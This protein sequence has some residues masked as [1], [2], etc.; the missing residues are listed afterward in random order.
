MNGFYRIPRLP[1]IGVGT[2]EYG[3]F[4]VFLTN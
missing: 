2:L 3:N 1:A 4:F